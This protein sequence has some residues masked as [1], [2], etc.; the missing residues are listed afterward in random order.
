MEH[1]NS[2]EEVLDEIKTQLQKNLSTKL[3]ALEKYYGDGIELPAP[4]ER[5]YIVANSTD[6]IPLLDVFPSVVII[7]YS[8]TLTTPGEQEW[9]LWDEE[10]G[11][12]LYYEGTMPERLNKAIYR[13]AQAI[14]SVLKQ[15]HATSPRFDLLGM[16]VAYSNIPAA[17]PLYQACEVTCVARVVRGY[18]TT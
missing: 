1:Y 14:V 12:R 8:E 5:S 9:D 6:V 7:G 17:G 11:V 3:A 2:L 10:I 4:H 16:A 15:I 18:E 13:Y